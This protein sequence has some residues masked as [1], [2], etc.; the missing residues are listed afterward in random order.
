[1]EGVEHPRHDHPKDKHDPKSGDSGHYRNPRK[2]IKTALYPAEEQLA[3]ETSVDSGYAI[4]TSCKIGT[5]PAW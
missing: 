4:E 1:V 3:L 5:V 2:L